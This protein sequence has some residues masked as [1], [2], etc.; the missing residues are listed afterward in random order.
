M[1][2]GAHRFTLREAAGAMGDFGTLFP[3]AIGLIL[4]C[5][6]NPTGLLVMMGLAN[7]FTGIG[8]RLPIPIE[9]MKVI[10]IVAISQ[11]WSREMVHAT[12][13]AT[14]LIW[15]LLSLSGAVSLLSRFTP[16]SVARGIQVALGVMLSLEA[17]RLISSWWLM[18]AVSMAVIM[19]LIRSR[20]IPAALVLVLMGLTV[21]AVRGDLA[22][23]RFQMPELP[24]FRV[25]PAG[26]AWRGMIGAGFAQLGL[27]AANAVIATTAMITVYWPD[28]KVKP[29]SLALSTGLINT[30]SALF[31]GM[32]ICHGS[33]GLAAQYAFGART[34]GANIIEG[35]IE[36]LLGVFFGATVMI[37]FLTFPEAI[38]GAMMLFVGVRLILFVREIRPDPSAVPFLV[39]VAVSVL[40]N[41][42][43]GLGAGVCSSLVISRIGKEKG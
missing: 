7:I 2:T 37:L 13:L 43:I 29:K 1:R 41:M 39:T 42:A 22:G 24:G 26:M 14:G 32:P 21:M 31:G 19:L 4:V 28:R 17:V 33:G 27:T 11:G 8:Y 16:V 18:G 5:G 6:L 25:P 15:I 36:T 38:L 40:T 30:L 35:T 23:I 10:A 34:G 12:G 3:L 20:K 9:P